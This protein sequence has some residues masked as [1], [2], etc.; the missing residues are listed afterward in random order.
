MVN[1]ADRTGR[2]TIDSD[3]AIGQ[4]RSPERTRTK[5]NREHLQIVPDVYARI[6]KEPRLP[7]I[8]QIWMPGT[9]TATCAR[10]DVINVFPHL[11][12]GRYAMK[13]IEGDRLHVSAEV[14]KDGH[15]KLAAEIVYRK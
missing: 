8:G 2:S 5:K 6:G 1:A 11:D 12:H 4:R 3:A 15:D 13:R 14:M 7:G 9:S 10:V